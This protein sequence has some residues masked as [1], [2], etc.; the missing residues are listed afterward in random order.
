MASLGTRQILYA[1][2]L[3]ST[4][5]TLLLIH[6]REGHVRALDFHDFESRMRRLL[7]LHYGAEGNDFAV[8]D[9]AAPTTI[10]R[11]ISRSQNWEL[12]NAAFEDAPSELTLDRYHEVVLPKSSVGESP[13]RSSVQL[14]YAEVMPRKPTPD[15]PEQ[16]KRFVDTAREIGA[17]GGDPEPFDR[18]LREVARSDRPKPTP[19][20]RRPRKP[21]DRG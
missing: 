18:V 8:E 14:Q 3:E 16:F 20:T 12:A 21:K 6:D 19:K 17:E 1:D 5:G 7:R 11:A 9:R 10:R 15:N 2:R 13:L 4:I